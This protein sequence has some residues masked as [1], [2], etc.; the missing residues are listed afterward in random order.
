[1]TW[2][3]LVDPFYGNQ[4][5]LHP[6]VWN[7]TSKPWTTKKVHLKFLK[8]NWW[9]R[10]NFKYIIVPGDVEIPSHLCSNVFVNATES[11][12]LE[13]QLRGWFQLDNKTLRNITKY[14]QATIKRALESSGYPAS[15]NN[16]DVAQNKFGEY[17]FFGGPKAAVGVD[18]KKTKSLRRR[19]SNSGGSYG[20]AASRISGRDNGRGK[21]S[22]NHGSVY[23]MLIPDQVDDH[24][25]NSFRYPKPSVHWNTAY[26]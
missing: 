21:P 11:I 24:E 19:L 26:S 25:N 5:I 13:N 15:P 6:Q 23:H 2:D 3:T 4:I 17:D 16:Y 18:L 1:M 7:I 20:G 9:R 10:T 14:E 8:F 12:R 22:N